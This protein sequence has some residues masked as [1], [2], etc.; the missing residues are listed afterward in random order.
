MKGYEK[1]ELKDLGS[2]S[3]AIQNTG[4]STTNDGIIFN[5]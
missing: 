5:S 3:T 4:P 2:F 1:P